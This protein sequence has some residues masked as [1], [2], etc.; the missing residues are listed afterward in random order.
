MY[1]MA[2]VACSIYGYSKFKEI[3]IENIIA[4]WFAKIEV[5]MPNV[6]YMQWL[7]T[8]WFRSWII[9]THW[10]SDTNINNLWHNWFRYCPWRRAIISPNAGLLLRGSLAAIF[11]DFISKHKRFYLM[12]YVSNGLCKMSFVIELSGRISWEDSVL[13]THLV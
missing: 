8:Q 1:M 5:N 4:L 2:S 12:K 9:W 13:H 6:G 10:R 11:S 3:P 7:F